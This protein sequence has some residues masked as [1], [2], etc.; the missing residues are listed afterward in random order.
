MTLWYGL[1][2]FLTVCKTG[3][4]YPLLQPTLKDL[5][6]LTCALPIRQHC[7]PI[8]S[9]ISTMNPAI[10][11]EVLRK[12][13]LPTALHLRKYLSHLTSLLGKISPAQHK[14]SAQT[15]FQN[16][17]SSNWINVFHKKN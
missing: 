2:K 11:L 9:K 5:C 14:L 13:N 6:S 1:S 15:H 4:Q 17:L 16:T 10:N 3:F 12:F 8:F 7:F